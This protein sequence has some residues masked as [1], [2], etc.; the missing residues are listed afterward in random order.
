M[1][2]DNLGTLQITQRQHASDTVDALTTMDDC[3]YSSSFTLY[4]HDAEEL[5]KRL[6][7]PLSIITFNTDRLRQISCT[8]LA[9]YQRFQE[10]LSKAGQLITVMNTILSS[11]EVSFL[12]EFFLQID[13][14]FSEIQ[15]HL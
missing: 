12:L 4:P 3:K 15:L 7:V 6:Q 10:Y 5:A 11:I 8:L 9:H 1:T 14:V 13:G 2:A